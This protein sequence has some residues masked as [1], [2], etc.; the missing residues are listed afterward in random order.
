[1][2]KRSATI[3]LR[4]A[5]LFQ[6]KL[7]PR[8]Q[9][10]ALTKPSQSVEFICCVQNQHFFLSGMRSVPPRPPLDPRQPCSMDRMFFLYNDDDFFVS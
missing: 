2:S 7:I 6:L 8:L 3:G 5:W 4:G 9:E 10:M 1:M